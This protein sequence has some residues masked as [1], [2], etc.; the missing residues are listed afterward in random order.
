MNIKIKGIFKD[1]FTKNV[2]MIASGAA[3]AQVVSLLL[4]PVIT[5]IYSPEEFSTLTLFI[6]ILGIISLLGTLSYESAIPIAENDNQA[7]NLLSLSLIILCL[8]SLLLTI[9]IFLFSEYFL[10]MLNAANLVSFKY[11]IVLGF[12]MTGLYSILIEWALRTKNYKG[13]ARTKYSQSII[14]NGGKIALG[15]MSFGPIGLIVGQIL[16][17]SAGILNLYIPI[18]KERKSLFI[19]I[20]KRSIWWCAKRYIKFPKFSAPTLFIISLTSQLPVLFLSAFYSPETVGYYGLALTITFLPMGIIGKSVEDVFYGEVASLGRLNPKEIKRLS[21]SLL[22]KLSI[23]GSMPMIILLLLGPKLFVFVFGGDWYNGGVF[24]ST[25]AIYG[26]THFIF[27]PISMVFFVFEE[28]QLQ[29]YLNI[30]KI[31]LVIFVF[32][33]AKILGLSAVQAILIFSLAM[34]GAEFGKY[35]LAQYVLK[36][37][38]FQS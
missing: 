20:D 35:L 38:S 2:I 1:R 11:F 15:L 23:I 26:F 34:A 7:V 29:L 9:F 14:G 27:H 32:Y 37:H 30:T 10:L 33:F 16:G 8:I 13:I 6:S 5:R 22:K 36:K 21:S 4:S 25:L 3:F 28:Q 12:F 18:A 17:Q 24:A 31:V 19:N